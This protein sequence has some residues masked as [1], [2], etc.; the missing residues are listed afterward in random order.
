MIWRGM[1]TSVYFPI[2]LVLFDNW[3]IL[4]SLLKVLDNISAPPPLPTNTI[5][6]RIQI[7]VADAP[8]DLPTHMLAVDKKDVG[9]GEHNVVTMLAIHRF[10]WDINRAHVPSLPPSGPASTS[11]P[12]SFYAVRRTVPIVPLGLPAPDAFRELLRYLYTKRAN[13]LSAEPLPVRSPSAAA[14]YDAMDRFARSLASELPGVELLQHTAHIRGVWRNAY[15][16]GVVRPPRLPL[17]RRGT[18]MA[19][20]SRRTSLVSHSMI[21]TGACLLPRCSMTHGEHPAR[22]SA[23]R[24]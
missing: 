17:I 19:R 3:L 7:E 11:C 1:G 15:A 4:S 8:A 2:V 13:E 22:C 6:S 12:A 10:I 5:S 20:Q 24:T 18:F 9:E 16:P 21:G 14:G 23:G